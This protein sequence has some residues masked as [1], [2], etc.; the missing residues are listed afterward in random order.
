MPWAGESQWMELGDHWAVDLL[1]TV[2]HENPQLGIELA[3][4][5]LLLLHVSKNWISHPDAAGHQEQSTTI[6]Q[7]CSGS[8]YKVPTFIPFILLM[9]S[10]TQ[11]SKPC[12]RSGWLHQYPQ[13]VNYDFPPQ[14]CDS[15]CQK[16]TFV[17]M[18]SFSICFLSGTSCLRMLALLLC[19]CFIH[20]FIYLQLKNCCS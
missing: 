15:Q 11:S 3:A 20:H 14:I 4:K 16:V 19:V 6:Q 7:I 17:H 1:M 13:S 5:L 12:S 8:E 2:W 18:L 10:L 9:F